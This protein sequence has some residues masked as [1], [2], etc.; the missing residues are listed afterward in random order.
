MWTWPSDVTSALAADADLLALVVEAVAD[1]GRPVVGAD[2]GDV[3]RRH[4]HVLVDDAGL[5]GGP[6]RPLVLLGHVDALDDDLVLLGEDAHDL[7]LVPAVLAGEHPHPVTLL[8][9]HHRPPVKT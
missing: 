2:D 7:A 3:G 4:R 8:Q 9:L 5:H 1:A 6:K